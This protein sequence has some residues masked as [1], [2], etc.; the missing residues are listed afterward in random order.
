MAVL[1]L[2]VDGIGIG[3]NDQTTNP[4]ARFRSPFF[5]FFQGEERQSLPAAGIGVPTTTDMNLPGLPQSATGQTALLTGVNA[6]SRL[7]RHHPG[8]PS[9]SLRRILLEESIFLKIEKRGLTATFANAFT[10]EYFQRRDRSISATTWAVKASGFPFRMVHPHL[11][12]GNAIS[13]DLTNQSLIERGH[14]VGIRTAEKAAGIISDICDSVDFCLF[15][16]FQTDMVGHDRDMAGAR[17]EIEKLDRFL[18]AL[19]QGLDLSR[20]TILLT[21]DHGNFEDLSTAGHTRNKVA[22]LIWGKNRD[23]LAKSVDRIEAIT[24]AILHFMP[25]HELA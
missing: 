2:F 4:F 20:H 7:G 13:H 5:C 14:T 1:L 21:S 6:A 10:P 16:Y 12:E 23:Q 24:P 22:T 15:E 3:A 25:T 8:F 11:A 19:L 17:V 18:E 9:A